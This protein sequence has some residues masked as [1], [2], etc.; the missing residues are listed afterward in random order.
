MPPIEHVVVIIK[1]NHTFD[2]YFGGFPGAKGVSL[3]AAADPHPDQNHDHAAW[4]AAA[5][6]AGG[7]KLQYGPKNIPATWA[8]AQQYVLCDQYFTDVASESEPNHLFL[9]AAD[10]PVIDNSTAQRAFQPSPP[11][12]MQ[13]LPA[14]LQQHG[15]QWRNY[16][17]SNSSYFTNIKALKGNAWNVSA[18][19]FDADLKKGFLPDVAWL[20]APYAQSEHPGGGRTVAEGDAWTRQRVQAVA[21]SALW[22]AT[23]LIITW[24]DW[25]GWYDHVTPPKQSTWPGQGP[26]GYHGSQFRYGNRVPCVVVSPYAGRQIVSRLYSHASV[27]KLCL[28]LF[29]LA[30]WSAPA[31]QPGDPSGDLWECFDF[32][33]PPRLA[34]PGF[35]PA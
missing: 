18:G 7:V 15:R 8:L 31:L 5:E 25:G 16:A 4:M 17:D 33:S 27:V 28:R 20:Y 2:N 13:S 21:Q 3:P 35:V 14:V 9:I 6:G 24:D 34:V 23:A 30:A 12:D 10:S 19:Q 29:G 1:E 11:F 22:P 32:Q 26:T